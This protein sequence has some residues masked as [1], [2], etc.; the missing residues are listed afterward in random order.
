MSHP[1]HKGCLHLSFVR[2]K[3]L[4]TFMEEFGTA[5]SPRNDAGK[6]GVEGDEK[7]KENVTG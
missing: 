5:E 2:R 1:S 7:E 4:W 6:G 3:G